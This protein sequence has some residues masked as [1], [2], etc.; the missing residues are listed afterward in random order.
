M[1]LNLFSWTRRAGSASMH[2]P[3][4]LL[5]NN[6]LYVLETIV[7]DN[8]NFEKWHEFVNKR[9]AEP[10]PAIYLHR[11]RTKR[12]V[13][14]SVT[15]EVQVRAPLDIYPTVKVPTFRQ[16]HKD[17]CRAASHLVDQLVY[18]LHSNQQRLLVK[19]SVGDESFQVKVPKSLGPWNLHQTYHHPMA[20]HP[21]LCHM[22]NK[23]LHSICWPNLASD[24]YITVAQC[25]SC[26][27]NKS[28]LH[29]N[30]RIQPI[31]TSNFVALGILG[32]LPK[33]Q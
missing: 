24:V 17:Y 20:G 29:Q 2:D 13:F 9:C 14:A 28:R 5:S 3:V 4:K 8:T 26:I 30:R 32:P 21:E 33:I 12:Q 19:A 6:T 23:P 1:L 15:I 11:Q 16:V 25:H 18:E 10:I 22:Y 31:L 7:E 27:R